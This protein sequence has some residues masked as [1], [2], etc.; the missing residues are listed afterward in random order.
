MAIAKKI[1]KILLAVVLAVILVAGI[2]VAYYLLSYKRIE[3]DLEL[4]LDNNQ[5]TQVVT[6][7]EYKAVSYNTGFGAYT[8]DFG[9]FMDGGT[10]GRAWSEDSVKSTVNGIIGLLSEKNAD[11]NFLQEVDVKAT[12]SYKVNELELYKTSLT[13]YTSVFAENYNSPY[14]IY[15]FHSP[16]GSAKSGILL[17]TKFNATNALRRSLPVE[18]G[19]AKY[20]DLDR[21]YTITALPVEN[22]KT[23][24]LFNVH[25]SAYTSDGK[26]ADEQFEMLVS[27]MK[28]AYNGGGYVICA[29]D[30]NKDVL[31]NGSEVFGVDGTKYTWAQPIKEEYLKDTG[32]SLQKPFD[33]ANPIPTCR[34]ADGPYNENQ[35]VVSIDGFIVSDNVEVSYCNVIDTGF[36]FSDHNPV[37]MHF[38]LK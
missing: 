30:F 33:P 6:G 7:K 27:D 11:I 15:P 34:N 13:G 1:L 20:M 21:C 23:L 8:K 2:Y 19:F 29:G 12:R 37:E 10:E 18:T 24:Y 38:T 22:G 17:L 25:L 31:G 9:F 3:S 26:I 36:E 4:T 28:E 16:L 32:L 35:F 14:L 5:T